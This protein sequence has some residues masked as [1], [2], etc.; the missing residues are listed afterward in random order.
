M[1]HIVSYVK[2]DVKG[3]KALIAQYPGLQEVLDESVADYEA[4]YHREG[5]DFHLAYAANIE[6]TFTPFFGMII[7]HLEALFGGG[8]SRIAAVMLWHFCEEIEH[9]S[10][11]LTVYDHVVGKR[12]YRLGQLRKVVKHIGANVAK[13]HEGFRKHVP[14]CPEGGSKGAFLPVPGPAMRRMLLGVFESQMPWHNPANG[15]VPAYY[16]DWRSSYESGGDMT[17]LH[18]FAPQLAS[19]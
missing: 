14:G 12:F 13:I 11:A 8:D 16:S 3:F 4:L 9:R 7:E 2:C 5:L 17:A 6:A 1:K 15:R 10:S 19:A 18:E